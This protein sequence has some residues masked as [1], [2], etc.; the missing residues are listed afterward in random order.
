MCLH[1]YIYMNTRKGFTTHYR[2][3]VY[4]RALCQV[5]KPILKRHRIFIPRC[6]ESVPIRMYTVCC[7]LTAPVIVPLGIWTTGAFSMYLG[8][9]IGHHVE[10]LIGWPYV[11]DR[12]R[13]GDSWLA[14]ENRKVRTC[15]FYRLIINSDIVNLKSIKTSYICYFFRITISFTIRSCNHVFF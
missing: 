6:A 10:G 3:Y 2:T 13:Q 7:V 4:R 1:R 15:A 14:S 12:C 11:G 8:R 9:L 5:G